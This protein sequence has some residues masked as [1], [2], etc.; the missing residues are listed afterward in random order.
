M[1]VPT[2]PA[3]YDM[4]QAMLKEPRMEPEA[5]P[6]AFWKSAK[7]QGARCWVLP[8]HRA[9]QIVLHIL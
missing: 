4:Q 7:G 5:S 2:A 1:A 6:M 3:G 9:V 8:C